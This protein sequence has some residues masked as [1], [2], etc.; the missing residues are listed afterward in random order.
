MYKDFPILQSH[1]QAGRAAEA[2]ECAGEQGKY[3]EMHA[4]LFREPGEWD[5][6]EA[7][8]RVAFEQYASALKLNLPAFTACFLEGRYRANIAANLAEGVSLGVTG[9]PAFVING[10]ILRGAHPTEVFT[11]A[12]N[13][14]LESIG[15]GQ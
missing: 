3:W 10:K 8:A 7:A 12:L 5:T 15:G 1:P 11:R 6:T 9:T 13:R 2:A 14:E 4:A